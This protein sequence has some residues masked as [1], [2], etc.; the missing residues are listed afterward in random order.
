LRT[1][2]IAISASRYLSAELYDLRVTD[3]I[4][5]LVMGITLGGIGIAACLAPSW[6]ASR[7]NANAMLK[8][9]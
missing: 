8:Q 7:M 9:E 5:W 3:P 4:T 1:S 2:A 6:R